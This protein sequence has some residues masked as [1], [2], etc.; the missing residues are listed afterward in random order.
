MTT[1]AQ[2]FAVETTLNEIKKVSPD[3]LTTFLFEQNGEIT[4]KDNE[5]DSSAASQA[6]KVFTDLVEK[7]DA[8]GG[9]ESATFLGSRRRM[10]ISRI[11]DSFLATVTSTESDEKYTGILTRVL[12][13]MILR[14]TDNLS[15][16]KEQEPTSQLTEPELTANPAKDNEVTSRNQIET[17][18]SA[19]PEPDAEQS[20]PEL[21]YQPSP[22]EPP[23]TQFIIEHLGGLLVQPDTVRLGN[24]VIRQW[25]DLYGEKEITEVDVETLNG[26]TTRC[27]FKPI[28]DSKLEGKGIIQMPQKI[29]LTLQTSNGELVMV[30]PV[31]D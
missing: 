22:A 2:A 29:Q 20:E 11:N 3:V 25:K 28:K 12:V 27:K 15:F 1:G 18:E 14:F 7:A 24:E 19:E 8:I 17:S 6:G 30:K 13:S 31:V 10:N 16:N 21:E 9:L 23:A 4:A 5:T 26:Q